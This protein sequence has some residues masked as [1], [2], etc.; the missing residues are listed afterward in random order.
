MAGKMTVFHFVFEPHPVRN[1][2]KSKKR[3]SLHSNNPIHEDFLIQNDDEAEK[4]ERRNSKTQNGLRSST[5]SNLKQLTQNKDPNSP[6]ATKQKLS[7][8]HSS[9]SNQQLA[10][11]YANCLKLCTENVF[12]Q[13]F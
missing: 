2:N 6:V 12:F 10:E 11:L 8:T 4:I 3:L 1:M 13:V 7:S 5:H 9:L